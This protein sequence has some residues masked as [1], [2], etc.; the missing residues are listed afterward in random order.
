MT[1]QSYSEKDFVLGIDG[2]ATKTHLI[3][4]DRTMQVLLEAY[5]E[6]SNLVSLM[7]ERVRQNLLELLERAFR[8]GGL[9]PTRCQ[10]ICLGSAGAGRE[11]AQRQ[12]AA[13]LRERF[14][15]MIYVTDDAETALEGASESGE[16]ILLVSGTGSI[17]TGTN[18]EGK[19]W[20][21]GG[22]GHIAGDEG[23]GYDMSCKILRAVVCAADGRGAP[24]AL[25]ALVMRQWNLTGID[26]LIDALYRTGKGKKEIA[27]L[28]F[29]CDIAY[30]NGDK[31]SAR[32]LEECANSLAELAVVA[33]NRLWQAG[34]EVPCFYT[35]G[36]LER[37]KT[38]REFLSQRLAAMRPGLA[39]RPCAHDAAWGCA[40]L[41]WK[42]TA[43]NRS[44][45]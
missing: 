36:L 11:T 15:G 33:A 4:V 13:I 19:R 9:S 30:N 38:L 7:A 27:A 34:K 16:G 29:L 2:G 14:D 43:G 25:T 40:S 22:W 21:T 8:E 39:L 44:P 42:K 41:A 37:S 35:G 31:V 6:S 18:A 45:A 20:R 1:Q 10:G 28:A 17:C 26:S 12:L 32:I 5:G 23:S 24:T 3:A